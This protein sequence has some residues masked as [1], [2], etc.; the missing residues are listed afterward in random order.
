MLNWKWRA[1]ARS[2]P[3]SCRR[4]IVSTMPVACVLRPAAQDAF[5]SVGLSD[6]QLAG[7][8]VSD[9]ID[10][11]NRFERGAPGRVAG[12]IDD[13]AKLSVGDEDSVEAGEGDSLWVSNLDQWERR[14]AAAALRP[15][16]RVTRP[17]DNK[18]SYEGC[19]KSGVVVGRS[20]DTP[21]SAQRSAHRGSR[22][23]PGGE[24]DAR[25]QR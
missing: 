23:R 7:A 20:V 10:A 21:R 22:R 17:L 1:C 24:S 18:S 9:Q 5:S 15:V 12:V 11:L 3:A 19:E 6:V 25:R 8:C 14:G 13:V 2:R 16:H 4:A